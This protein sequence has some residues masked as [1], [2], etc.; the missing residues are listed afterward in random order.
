M[1]C[2]MCG[3]GYLKP[4]CNVTPPYEPVGGACPGFHR[5]GVLLQTAP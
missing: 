4:I 2:A 1:A 5:F 3:L